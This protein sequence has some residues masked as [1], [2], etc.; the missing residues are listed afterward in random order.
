MEISTSLPV[1]FLFNGLKHHRQLILAFINSSIK[2]NYSIVEL[3]NRMKKIGISM[4]DLYYGELSPEEISREIAVE[5]KRKGCFDKEKY[6]HYINNGAKKY[7]ALTLSD[8]SDWTLL[9]GRE[10]DTYIHFHPSRGSMFTKRVK[11]ISIR[12]AIMLKIFYSRELPGGDLISL[13]NKVRIDYLHESPV[14]NESDT[15][16]LKNVLE[17]L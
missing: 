3:N 12:T 7:R 16:R 13:I 6:Q 15:I 4:I 9:V 5:L 1:P 11:A 14:K 8:G 17:V 2:H 10:A